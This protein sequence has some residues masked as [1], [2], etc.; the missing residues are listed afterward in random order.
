MQEAFYSWKQA[1]L[2]F[3]VMDAE[4]ERKEVRE[5][6]QCIRERW[7]EEQWEGMMMAVREMKRWVRKKER[8]NMKEGIR[9]IHRWVKRI[10]RMERAVKICERIIR[11]NNLRNWMNTWKISV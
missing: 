3:K 6:Y 2:T 7:R 5:K 1:H 10:I 11:R 4:E 9:K 8:K